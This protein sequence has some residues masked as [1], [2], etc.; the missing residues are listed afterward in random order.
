MFLLNVDA[1]CLSVAVLKCYVFRDGFVT[2]QDYMA[3]MISRETENV[4][5]TEE[6]ENAFR[7]LSA[8]FRPYVTAEELYAVSVLSFFCFCC[9]ILCLIFIVV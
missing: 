1:V 4:Q 6:I 2:L 9:C 8:E 3:F 7:A 5:S